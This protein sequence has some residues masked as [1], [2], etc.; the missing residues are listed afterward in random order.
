MTFESTADV[1]DSEGTLIP[2]GL[3][4]VYELLRLD[5]GKLSVDYIINIQGFYLP[6][7]YGVLLFT[8]L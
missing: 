7:Q 6:D 4:A 1:I 5:L 3:P 2:Y 8:F